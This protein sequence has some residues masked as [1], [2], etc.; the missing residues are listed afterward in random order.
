MIKGRVAF[1]NNEAGGYSPQTVNELSPLLTK[2]DAQIFPWT[3][4]ER[5]TSVL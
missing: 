1:I 2:Y 5:A 3:D 4:R